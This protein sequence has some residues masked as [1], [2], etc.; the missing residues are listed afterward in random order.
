MNNDEIFNDFG[1]VVS[2]EAT[3]SKDSILDILKKY[4]STVS[5]FDL[6]KI[7]AEMMEE[8]KYVQKSYRDKSTGIYA[9][10]FLARLKDVS[11]DNSHYDSN[12]DKDEFIDAVATLK[13]YQENESMN[14]KTKFPLVYTIISL[15]TTFIVEEP[16]HPVGTPF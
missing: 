3:A 11:S 5:V 2:G 4:S 15:Y 13:S 12:V 1:D 9:K 6:M 10:Y 8:S 14:N 16:I 7:S